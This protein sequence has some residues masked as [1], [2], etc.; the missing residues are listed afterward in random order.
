MG[1]SAEHTE[2]TRRR[3]VEAAGRLFRRHGFAGAKIDEIMAE[4]ELTRGGFYAHFDSK[5]DLFAA[6]MQDELE[7]TRQL[8]LAV[9]RDP[10]GGAEEAIAYYLDP[11]N[12]R[13]IARG[14]T[15]VSNAA[16]LA[17]ANAATRKR[18]ARSFD[19]LVVEFAAI[20]RGQSEEEQRA[21]GLAALSTCVGAV[22]LARALQGEDRI[23]ELLESAR[24]GALAALD[25]R[26]FE[27]D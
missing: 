15:V 9:E 5:S 1:Y 20:A 18:F 13:K 8:R 3:I 26:A 27:V 21:R 23:E 14:C 7:F 11:A 17:R 6:V 24:S 22:V 2:R 19:D 4:A 16:D 10:E 12:R 25:G